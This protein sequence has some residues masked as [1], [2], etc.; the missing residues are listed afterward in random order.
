MRAHA[1]CPAPGRLSAGS[2]LDHAAAWPSPA[3]APV[4]LPALPAPAPVTL[5]ALPHA[6]AA[7]AN[8]PAPRLA[9]RLIWCGG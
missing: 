6:G 1:A 9:N 5:L 4:T 3:P 7:L 8:V 2:A